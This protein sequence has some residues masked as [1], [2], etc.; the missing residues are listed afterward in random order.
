MENEE[1]REKLAAIEHERWADWQRYMHSMGTWSQFADI[2]G[3]PPKDILYFP[4][5]Y[6]THLERQ[7]NTTYDNLSE[8]EKQSDREQ[9]DRY[10]PLLTQELNKARLDELEKAVTLAGSNKIEVVHKLSKFEYMTKDE[11]TNQLKDEVNQ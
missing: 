7:I 11:R 10:L 3:G 1:L 2:H 6:I 5:S 4:A 8:A 9:V